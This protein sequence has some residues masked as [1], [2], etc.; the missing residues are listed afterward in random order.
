MRKTKLGDLGI[1]DF[2]VYGC[3]G[4]IGLPYCFSFCTLMGTLRGKCFSS[5]FY[6]YICGNYKIYGVRRLMCSY[7]YICIYFFM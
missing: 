7:S 5:N 1:V 2:Q 3:F 6:V 4:S